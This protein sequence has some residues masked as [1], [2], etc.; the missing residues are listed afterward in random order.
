MSNI[1]LYTLWGILYIFTT[2]LGFIPEAEGFLAGLLIL[3]AIA[4]FVPGFVLLY[5]GKKKTVRLLS[6]IS[7]GSTVLCL[8][9]NVWS[10][11][12]S[13]DMGEFLYILLG[14]LSAPM[15]CGRIWLIGLFGWAC[16]LMGSVMKLPTLDENDT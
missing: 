6:L 10:V 13:P 1:N 14:I 15:F 3:L 9:L 16:L 5:R 12:L 2:G 4:F 8:L 11:G 7:L